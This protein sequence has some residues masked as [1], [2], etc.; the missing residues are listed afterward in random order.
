VRSLTGS[1]PAP[2]ITAPASLPTN[3]G[4][5]DFH[6]YL[7]HG[8]G[9]DYFYD[10][11]WRDDAGAPYGVSIL[12]NNGGAGGN[13][14]YTH[15]I[16]AARSELFVAD[17]ADDDSPFYMQVNYTI[18]HW[19][20]DAIA[21]AP[22]GY[23]M[24][25]AMPWTTQQKAYAAMITRM[26]ASIG[27]LME[28]LD[29]P[30]GDGNH[31]DSIAHNTLVLFT[32]DNG[33]STEDNSP[34]DFFNANGE[35]RGGK[36]EL[37]EGGVHMPA[38]AYWPGTI[39]PGS[40]SDY[41]T[42]LADF[43][44]TAA[45]LAGVEAPVGID[46]VS[47]APTLTGEGRQRQRDYLVFEHQGGHGQDPDPRI[48]RWSVVRQDGM[49]LIRYDNDTMDLF[50][51]NTDPD[52]NSPLS[53]GIPANAQTAAEMQAV[54][55]AE[56]LL[57]GVVEYRNYNGPN[58][59]NVQDDASWDGI[60]RPHGY[61]SAVVANTTATP[62]IAH[63]SADVAT[64][65]VEVRGDTAI[66]VVDVH[67]DQTLT[68]RNEVRIGANGRVDLSGGTLASNRWVNVR[69]NGEL[70]GHGTV[71]GDVYNEGTLSPGRP[72]DS[73]AWPIATP[74]ALPPIS[75]DTGVVTATSFNFAGVQDDVPL[76][77][78]STLSPYVEVSQGLD[79][80][81][82]VGPRLGN[83]GTDEGDEFNVAGHTA[84]SLADAIT[85]GD[86][87]TFSVDPIAGAGAIPS[88]VSFR[89]WRNGGSAGKNWA[90]LSSVGGFTS[91]AALV[92]ATYTDT[93]LSNQHT[94]TAS[95]PAVEA[96][97]E[98]IEYRLYGWGGTAGTGNTHVNLASLNARFIAV[99][100]LEFNFAGVQDTAPL[101]A[102]R[103]QDAQVSL[104]AGLN[105]GPGVV[106]RGANNAGN[107]LHVAGFSTGS[108]LQSAI[109]SGDYLSFSV[110]AITGMAMI[111]DTVSFTLWRQASTS[112]ADYAIL[113]SVGGFTSGQDLAQ[114]HI[115][116]VGAGN[117]QVF[118]GAFAGAQ[119]TTDP[120]EFRLYGWNAATALDS[121]HVVAASMRARFASVAGSAIDPTGTLLVQG[122]LFHLDGG[123]IAIDLGGHVAGVDYDRLEVLGELELEGRLIVSL[124]D[125]GGNPFAPALNDSFTIL[126]ATQGVTGEFG[127]VTLPLLAM[128]LD[129]RVDY[130]STAVAL[131]VVE[132]ADFNRDGFIDAADY[133]AWR[134]NGG[135]VD[136]YNLWRA[137]FG[138]TAGS[139]SGATIDS[140]S[141][142]VP[143]PA[144]AVLLLLCAVAGCCGGRPMFRA[145][146]PHV[147]HA[148]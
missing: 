9:H 38:L 47:I 107:E 126:F 43:L 26:D 32:S 83:G 6:G 127:D 134:K 59:G 131:T 144:T 72:N 124:T 2:T 99:S 62:R 22:G 50:D 100:S 138:T 67:S 82:G 129:W 3:H 33:P 95:I 21:S 25:A 85:N 118:T 48:G 49:K 90:I 7:N 5:E 77:A 20:I 23:G 113:S 91:G 57:R 53:L 139:G 35:Y 71:A 14:A 79:F 28:R 52:E 61:W 63:V 15:D 106:P 56:G 104:T 42:D 88:S 135:T 142:Q 39:A 148:V 133:V 143:E 109:D 78:T 114:S 98:P 17:H 66:Q 140:P 69:A 74:P 123:V 80:G 36:F 120:V 115:T 68:G 84:T 89:L 27:A 93:G 30:N 45:D 46:G 108:T 16:F 51:L 64:L 94:L 55:V 19:D 147:K 18:P 125:I 60:G 101:T 146:R 24:Y 41:R 1:D 102:L 40:S 97:T 54:A 76:L 81:P 44:A 116:T 65:G 75:L 141:T 87:L 8:A 136:Q 34:I 70:R 128:G 92:Q 130:L 111:P 103:R 58:G 122:D 96:L 105:F 121:T 145:P 29:D 119:P 11:M 12:A 86:Y 31:A 117:Q 73:P 137:N 110:Q 37:Y 10:W 4:F 132:T 112:A 13:P